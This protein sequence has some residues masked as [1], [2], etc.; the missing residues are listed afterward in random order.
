LIALLIMGCIEAK[1]QATIDKAFKEKAVM[2]IDKLM[3]DFYVYPDVAK[4]TGDHLKKQ[5]ESG[6]FDQFNDVES[7]SKALTE[8]VQAINKD[9]HMRV[10]PSAG[11]RRNNAPMTSEDHV[12]ALLK[13]I[14]SPQ[15]SPGGFFEAKKLRGNVGY[16]EIRGFANPA[17]GAP[18]ADAYMKLLQG[19]DAMIIDLRKNGGGSP[20]MVQYLCS[21]FFDKKVHLNSIYHREDNKTKEYWTLENVGGR[22]MADVPLF[23]LTSNY[24]FSGA[25]EFSYNMQ[26]QKRATLIGETT[27]GGANPGGMRRINDQLAIFIPDGAAINPIT[28]TNWEGTGVTPEVKTTA[29]AALEKGIELATKAAENY[30]ENKYTAGKT[31]LTNLFKNL[32]KVSSNSAGEQNMNETV[33]LFKTAIEKGLL[34]E[35]Q[36]NMLGYAEM[37]NDR[38]GMAEVILKANTLLFPTS[39]NTYDSYAEALAKNNKHDL[40]LKAYERAVEVASTSN[41]PNIQLYKENL[42]KLKASRN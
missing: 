35:A 9:K 8:E 16:L 10:V 21:Y 3:N 6:K 22:K 23:V 18:I 36:I 19:S 37:E 24:T 17:E 15:G 40:A 34:N 42:A 31:L 11:M 27:G 30:R 5:F 28:K 41:D 20:E 32:E 4:K 26:T 25:E 33:Q 29:E 12:E 1:A 14:K 38:A 2:T 13:S 7:F 39:P